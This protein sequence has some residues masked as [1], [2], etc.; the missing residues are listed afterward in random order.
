MRKKGDKVKFWSV[1]ED[2]I[3]KEYMSNSDDNVQI[4]ATVSKL[5]DRTLRG[6]YQRIIFFRNGQNFDH[7]RVKKVKK[8]N[9]SVV[10]KTNVEQG[11]TI[12]E[13]FSFDINN[14]K[15][16]VMFNGHVRLYF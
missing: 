15:R 5:L 8:E 9:V 7:K 3:L 6:V 13:G 14:V 12:P 16:A 10:K 11:I 1:S 4:A 2:N